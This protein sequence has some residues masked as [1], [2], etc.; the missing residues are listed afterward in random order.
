MFYIIYI[1]DWCLGID[2]CWWWRDVEIFYNHRLSR[3]FDVVQLYELHLF[4][5]VRGKLGNIEMDM[6]SLTV[7]MNIYI[8]IICSWSNMLFSH[9][10]YVY[11][12]IYLSI[13]MPLYAHNLYIYMY[14]IFP[15][16]AC[17]KDWLTWYQQFGVF[18]NPAKQLQE[19]AG[20]STAGQAPGKRTHRTAKKTKKPKV[21]KWWKVKCLKVFFVMWFCLVFFG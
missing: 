20:H 18:K 1:Y 12:L 21:S 14:I 2:G 13:Y 3:V 5:L 7:Y 16:C 19:T 17:I 8:Y 9:E 15:I 10:C 6:H 4:L 11:L